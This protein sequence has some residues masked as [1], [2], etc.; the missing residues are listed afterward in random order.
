LT[1]SVPISI[2]Q[3]DLEGVKVEIPY[4]FTPSTDNPT[5]KNF[6][7]TDPIFSLIEPDAPSADSIF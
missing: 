3:A 2:S 5:F 4:D 7:M 1:V 6:T